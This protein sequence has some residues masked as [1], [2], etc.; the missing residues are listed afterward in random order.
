[1]NSVIQILL[2]ILLIGLVLIVWMAWGILY[3]QEAPKLKQ[4]IK[5]I[6]K[7]EAVIFDDEPK[8]EEEIAIEREERILKKIGSE[9]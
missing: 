7:Q 8:T 3:F 4:N 1:M 6:K 2:I 9:K 5:Q